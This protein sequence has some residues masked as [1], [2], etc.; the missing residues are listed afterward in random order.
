MRRK[1]SKL[2]AKVSAFQDYSNNHVG[3]EPTGFDRRD[4]TGK[5]YMAI[6]PKRRA[7][8]QMRKN[9]NTIP[10]NERFFARKVL[11]KAMVNGVHFEP[12]RT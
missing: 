9:W 5:A 8:R 1:V 7:E 12:A 3:M 2:I 10:K 11:L 6:N 4:G